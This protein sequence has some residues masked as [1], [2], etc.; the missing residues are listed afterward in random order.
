MAVRFGQQALITAY[1]HRGHIIM[2]IFFIFHIAEY[3]MRL[4]RRLEAYMIPVEH[5]MVERTARV[6]RS[7]QLNYYLAELF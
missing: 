4:I 2:V 7:K 6:G 1:A 5:L 3:C